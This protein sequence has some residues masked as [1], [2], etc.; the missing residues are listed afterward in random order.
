MENGLDV[1]KK[2]HFLQI[3]SQPQYLFVTIF[4]FCIPNQPINLWE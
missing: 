3:G 4:T 1:Y 2:P